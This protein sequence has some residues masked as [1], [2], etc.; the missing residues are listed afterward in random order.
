MAKSGEGAV[1]VKVGGRDL[2]MDGDA[3]QSIP[4]RMVGS[5]WTTPDQLRVRSQRRRTYHE[6]SSSV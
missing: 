5:S 6:P 3:V 2:S 4:S 1:Y